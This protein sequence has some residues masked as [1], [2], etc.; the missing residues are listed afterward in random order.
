VDNE[1]LQRKKSTFARAWA[2]RALRRP[3]FWLVLLFALIATAPAWIVQHPPLQDMPFHLATIRLVHSIHDSA[4][5]FDEHFVL[6]LGRTQYLAYY[7]LGDLLAYVMGIKAANILLMCVYLGGTP[8]ALR[9]FLVASGRDPRLALF[10]IP[11]TA[12]VMFQFGLL[13]FLLGIPVM[14]WALAAAAVHFATPSRVSAIALGVLSVLCFYCHIFPFILFALGLLVMFPWRILDDLKR[15]T[16]AIAPL[17]PVFFVGAHWVF[18]TEAGKLARTPSA[19]NEVPPPIAE[20][21]A[22]GWSW[23]GDIFRDQTDEVHWLVVFGFA[24]LGLGLAQGGGER[25]HVRFRLWA[26]LPLLCGIAYFVLPESR[27]YYWLFAQRFPTLGVLL[28]IPLLRIPR[29]NHGLAFTAGLALLGVS[30]TVNVCQHFIAFERTEV[31]DLDDAIEHI[32]AGRK[33][34][35][36]IYDKSSN[37]MQW[38]PFLHFGSYAQ[39]EKGGVLQF[40][41]AGYSHWPVDYKPGKYPPPGTRAPLRWEWTPEQRSV[42]SELAPYYD[43]VLTRGSGFAPQESFKRVYAGPKWSVWQRATTPSNN[44][45][46]GG[47]AQ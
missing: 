13:P 18:F 31:G 47:G 35:A 26:V 25:A 9:S 29:A 23:L 10:A 2:L 15:A 30:S 28:A 21:L 42:Q 12:N 41:Y 11:V 38:A 27:G 45:G 24:I 33:V 4:Y 46:A 17:V 22:R 1:A 32:P 8:L 7:V 39:V 20:S 40:S 34:A 37:V 14:F 6:A 44:G 16:R 36:L 19:Q 3:D 5:G 43:Y